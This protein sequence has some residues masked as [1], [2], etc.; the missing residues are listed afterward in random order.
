M[1][2]KFWTHLWSQHSQ[3][4]FLKSIPVTSSLSKFLRKWEHTV[5]FSACEHWTVASGKKCV[6]SWKTSELVQI[7]SMAGQRSETRK[8][9]DTAEVSHLLGDPAK[10]AQQA[11][12]ALQERWFLTP[13]GLSGGKSVRDGLVLLYLQFHVCCPSPGDRWVCK[14]PFKHLIFLFTSLGLR[15]P[16]LLSSCKLKPL[17]L[18]ISKALWMLL[19]AEALRGLEALMLLP[20]TWCLLLLSSGFGFVL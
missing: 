6:V 1:L 15:S 16:K 3:C 2:P 4:N 9:K 17:K 18:L 11:S 8:M 7:F 10:G 5:A 20:H 13:V 12:S 14:S 19:K